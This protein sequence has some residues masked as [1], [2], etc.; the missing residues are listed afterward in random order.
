MS[1]TPA[2]DAPETAA[3]TAVT[4]DPRLWLEEVEGERA[5]DTVRAWNATTLEELQSDAR[6]AAL[7][8]DALA[9]V[10]AQDKLPYGGYRA[11]RV[12]NFW[13]D[14]THVRGMIRRTSLESYLSGATEWETVLDVDALAAEEGENWVY[15]G[16]TCLPPDYDRCML[17]LSRGGK[18]ATVSREWDHGAKAFIENG[19]F[20]PESKGGLSWVNADVQLVATDWERLEAGEAVPGDQGTAEDGP[21][22]AMTESGYPYIIKLARRGEALSEARE[23]FRGERTDVWTWGMRLETSG[24]PLFFASQ[25]KTFHE[26]H[27]H[28]LASVGADGTL[29]DAAPVRLPI[30]EKSGVA[31]WFKGQMLVSLQEDWL[32]HGD[33]IFPQGA[34]VSFEW[35]AFAETKTLPPVRLVYAPG[36][37]ESLSGAARTQSR[38]LLARMENVRGAVDAYD[39]VD[40]DWVST[41]LNLPALGSTNVVSADRASDVAFINYDGYLTPDTLAAMDVVTGET[42]GHLSAP[43]RFAAEGLTVQQFEATSSDGVAIPYFIVHRDDIALDGSNPTLLYGYGGF[44]IP[45]TPGY[46]ALTGK[47]WLERGGVYVVANIRGGGEFGPSWHQAALATQRQV[48]FDDFIAVAEDLIAR[49]VTSPRRLGVMGGSNGG[50]LVGAMYT[51]RPDLFRAVVCAVPLLDMLRFHL[52]LAGASW[53][54][55]YGDPDKPQERAFLQSISPYHNVQADGDYPHIF[56]LTSTKDDRVHPGHA[57]KMAAL[58]E[59]HGHRFSYYE[60]IDGGHAAAANLQEAAKRTA[61]QYMFLTREL[62]DG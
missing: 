13:Q 21:S 59:E 25:G 33:V 43:A 60:N 58:L 45:M 52:L 29:S 8:A 41:R 19:F 2:P 51:Q 12:M 17:H 18:D 6:Y 44:E 22:A 35:E 40:G 46:A 55:E 54:G 56:F 28:W 39:F 53:V 9:I 27:I 15:K 16:S 61:L 37:R 36:P 11:G 49:G 34:L 1:D 62:M 10:N 24:D 23:V 57:R 47:L 32:P 38:L 14:E 5:L 48:A 30:P 7:E 50:L 42:L 3:D 31:G 26:H 20:I 4:E